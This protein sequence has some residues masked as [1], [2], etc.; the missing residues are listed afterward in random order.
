[1]GNT[2]RISG[3]EFRGRLIKSGDFKGLRPTTERNREAIFSTLQSMNA[4]EGRLVL[5]LYAG[6]GILALEALSRGAA[7]ATLVDSN[8]RCINVIKENSDS[9]G[10]AEKIWAKKQS[11]NSFLKADAAELYSLVFADP[12]YGEHPGIGLIESLLESQC[13]SP[14]AVVV[15]ESPQAFEERDFEKVCA[16]AKTLDRELIETKQRS[17]GDSAFVVFV[18]A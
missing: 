9:L 18:F 12:P 3:G 11:V 16:L 13:L 17:K 10:L 4:I 8:S 6:T 2:L 1:M 14:N 7:Q 5:D 15:L